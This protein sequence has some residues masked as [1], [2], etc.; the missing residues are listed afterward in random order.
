MAKAAGLEKT[1]HAAD[2]ADVDPSIGCG[3][4]VESIFLRLS[5]VMR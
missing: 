5:G 1:V 4:F 2:A 3:L